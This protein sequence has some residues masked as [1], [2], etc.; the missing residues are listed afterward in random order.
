MVKAN[1]VKRNGNT[2]N[3]TIQ[4]SEFIDDFKEWKKH[5]LSIDDSRLMLKNST[6]LYDFL[7]NHVFN[8]IRVGSKNADR[9]GE[10]AREALEVIEGILED[11]RGITE[12]HVI[13]IK[14]MAETVLSHKNTTLDPK[15][16]LFT[17]YEEDEAGEK[18]KPVKVRGHYRTE[19]YAKKHGGESVPSEWLSGKNP[20]HM[21]LFSEGE[22][23]WAKPKGL[24]YILKDAKADIEDTIIDYIY[25]YD[26]V[27]GKNDAKFL[28]EIAALERFMDKVVNDSKF[29][30]NGGKLL[31]PKLRKALQSQTFDVNKGNKE[32]DAV[33]ALT[34]AGKRGDKGSLVGKIEHFQIKRATSLPILS[35]VDNALKRKGTNKAPNGYRAWQ[36][37]RK[38]GFDYRKTARELYPETYAEGKKPD[39][40]KQRFRPDAKIIS[41]MW[42][43][44]LWRD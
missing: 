32:Q 37:E 19:K 36:G 23:E 30:N 21:A 22:S 8:N 17:E 4:G 18:V 38:T 44:H 28:E 42:Q 15:D 11:K 5:C 41:K 33:R 35:L 12:N 29:W 40:G 6:T 9:N 27:A 31:V 20:P 16:I 14:A 26:L 10:G 24:Y 39:K 25:V 1:K 34:G 13:V 43:A 3:Q 7:F 2:F